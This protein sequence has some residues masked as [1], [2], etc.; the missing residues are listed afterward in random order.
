MN[1]LTC[2]LALAAISVSAVAVPT[3]K[4]FQHVV[5]VGGGPVNLA[6][7]LK[8]KTLYP[9][10]KVQIFEKYPAFTRMNRVAIKKSSWAQLQSLGV[11]QYIPDAARHPFLGLLTTDKTGNRDHTPLPELLDLD[12][13]FSESLFPVDW[14][15]DHLKDFLLHLNPVVVVRLR[16]LE[17]ALSQRAK[18]LDIEIT[19]NCMVDVKQRTGTNP[20]TLSYGDSCH[21]AQVDLP[22]NPDLIVLAKGGGPSGISQLEKL[23]IQRIKDNKTS[24]MVYLGANV[25]VEDTTEHRRTRHQQYC[26]GNSLYRGSGARLQKHLSVVSMS[27]SR[28]HPALHFTIDVL[29]ETK[30]WVLVSVPSDY[31][32]LAKEGAE[33]MGISVDKYV[34]LVFMEEAA[35]MLGLKCLTIADSIVLINA[36]NIRAEKTAFTPN[37]LII[38]DNARS[39]HFLTGSGLNYALTFDVNNVARAIREASAD[40]TTAFNNFQENTLKVTEAWWARG[41]VNVKGFDN[42]VSQIVI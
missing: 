35:E 34:E 5:G 19:H 36:E 41:R 1:I 38:G 10:V 40:L 20:F 4:S 29:E 22:T 14:E 25:I 31:R 32:D 24:K 28:P 13:D 16:D 21:N 8:V 6:M 42:S 26:R 18:E 2:I 33:R 30:K 3:L 27:E 15:E 39:G 12:S 9:D 17:N 23:G 37:L 7:A 11:T